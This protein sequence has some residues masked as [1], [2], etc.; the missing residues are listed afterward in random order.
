VRGGGTRRDRRAGGVTHFGRVCRPLFY[1]FFFFRCRVFAPPRSVFALAFVD[2]FAI[3]SPFCFS[4]FALAAALFAFVLSSLCSDLLTP[5]LTFSLLF[6]ITLISEPP[7]RPLVAFEGARRWGGGAWRGVQLPRCSLLRPARFPSL[8]LAHSRL[9]EC[10]PA[11]V[12]LASNQWL[13][14]FCSLNSSFLKS[15][16]AL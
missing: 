10:T 15:V 3:A 8:F 9:V 4:L 12:L 7:R 5:F 2:R 1:F 11:R 6:S 16:N 14:D 13:I